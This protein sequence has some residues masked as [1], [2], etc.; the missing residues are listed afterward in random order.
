MAERALVDLCFSAMVL[1][2]LVHAKNSNISIVI[3]HNRLGKKDVLKRRVLVYRPSLLIS[4]SYYLYLTALV[5]TSF[6]S[7]QRPT[8]LAPDHCA[9]TGDLCRRDVQQNQ[10]SRVHWKGEVEEIG[11]QVVQSWRLL[12]ETKQ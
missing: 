7:P 2:V 5:V 12:W 3:I 4:F 9:Y 6:G 10:K 1:K 11:G 8:N